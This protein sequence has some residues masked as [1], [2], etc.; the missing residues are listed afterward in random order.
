MNGLKHLLFFFLIIVILPIA[1]FSQVDK[2]YSPMSFMISDLNEEIASYSFQGPDVE[3]C[4]AEDLAFEEAGGYYRIGRSVAVNVD[5]MKLA[6]KFQTRQENIYRIKLRADGAE[7]LI[8]GFNNFFIPKGGRLFV[9]NASKEIIIGAYTH[10]NN[11]GT[12]QLATELIGDDEII[13]EYN[14]PANSAVSASL[15][16]SELGYV[17]RGVSFL[18]N[19]SALGFGDADPCEVNIN[20]TPEG[21]NWQD[22]KRGV[23]R[24]LLKDG[25]NYGWCSGSLV[26]NVEQDFQPYFLTA[27]HCGETSSSSDYSFWSFYFNF[28]SANCSNPTSSPSYDVMNGCTKIANGGSG[29]TTGS[30]FKLLLF[31]NSIPLG[32][33]VYF[34]GWDRQNIASTGGVSIHHPAG[35]IKKISTYTAT[36]IN[37]DWN[38]SGYN[39]HWKVTW[40]STINGHGVTEGG[41]SGSPIFNNL[42]RIVGDLTGGSSYC[43]TPN[44][45]DYY[46]K[47][48]YSWESNGT[49]ATQRLKNW[50][51]PNGT[52]VL[53]LDGIDYSIS[54]TGLAASYCAGDA[55]DTL[56]G[57]PAGGTFTGPGITGNMFNPTLAGPGTHTI[58]YTTAAGLTTST[59][60]VNADPV[61]DL[62]PDQSIAQGQSVDLDAGVGFSSYVW[63][64]G[65]TIQ[66]VSVASSGSYSCT[67]TDANGCQGSDDVYVDV[68]LGGSPGWY[69]SNTGT[70]HSILIQQSIPITINGVQIENGDYIGVFYDSLGTIACG[71]Y[72]QWANTTSALTAWGSQPG[73]NDGFAAN[74]S[75]TWMIWDASDSVSYEALADYNTVFFSDVGNFLPNGLSGLDALTASSIQTQTLNFPQGW[76]MF[77]T[78]IDPINPNIET[79]FQPIINDLVIVKTGLGA[80]YW[81]PFYNG[82]G[83][84]IIG[85]GYQINVLL[86]TTLDIA[87]L[88]VVPENTSVALPAG[89]SMVGYLRQSTADLELMWTGI[90][91]EIIIAKTGDGFVY[92]P[93]FVNQIGVLEPGKGYQLKLT[94]AAVLVYPAN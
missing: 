51:D 65:E 55:I 94:N 92:W 47:F 10:I 82:I 91:S 9:Y 90:L 31:S 40:T 20:C 41:S 69:F 52:D 74:E 28:E 56:V 11:Q 89:W 15:N 4:I 83:N 19:K 43:S 16:I 50:L 45:P 68:S 36:L 87:G 62:G 73:L 2:T 70:N 6:S 18:D 32:Y 77:S 81:P 80:V 54:I 35:D 33:N 14:E 63:S 22:E 1:S 30:D 21:D 72:L 29:G 3:K 27:D 7:A 25:V 57:V 12:G 66:L 84:M 17:Y 37:D 93:P 61:I 64:S 60:T 71:G 23:A 86:T 58:T 75:F 39:S 79:V 34:N 76:S 44:W 26:N 46:G 85:E 49:L 38:G 42:G 5:L 48:S 67:V 88:A 24:I 13:I 53:F 78:Y 8:V 59:V